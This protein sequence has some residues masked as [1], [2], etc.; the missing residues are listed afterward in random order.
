MVDNNQLDAF[1]HAL[2]TA[3]AAHM[4]ANFPS[5]DPVTYDYSVGKKFAKIVEGRRGGVFCFVDLATG[6]ILKAAGYNAPAKGARGH[7]SNGAAD[8]TPY[9]ATY[10]NFAYATY[11]DMGLA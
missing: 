9:G 10:K 1:V 5:L 4:Q 2:T 7:I 3:K 6:D 8:V 11:R